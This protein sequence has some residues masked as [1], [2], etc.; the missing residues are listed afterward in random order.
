MKNALELFKS[1][2]K[3]KELL[4]FD[5]WYRFVKANYKTKSC[6]QAVRDYLSSLVVP[7][8]LLEN[9]KEAWEVT[10]SNIRQATDKWDYI[11]VDGLRVYFKEAFE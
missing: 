11:L 10:V 9:L 6:E 4:G 5:F 1:K 3:V 8:D 7:V 2:P